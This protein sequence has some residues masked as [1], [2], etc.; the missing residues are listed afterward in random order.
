MS[1][2]RWN[3]TVTQGSGPSPSYAFSSGT[4]SNTNH[5][6]SDGITYDNAGNMT[7]DDS[8]YY[9]Y[10]GNNRVIGTEHPSGATMLP[11]TRIIPEGCGFP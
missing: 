1:S 2:H 8:Y 4:I 9:T 11:A 10:D 7:Y 6:I 3:Q 5:I